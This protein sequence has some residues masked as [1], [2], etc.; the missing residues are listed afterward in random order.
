[1]YENKKVDDLKR[2]LSIHR[3]TLLNHLH[4]I[5]QEIDCL[6]YLQFK[7]DKED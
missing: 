6:D 2:T 4:S 7:L 3:K 1:M 5:H